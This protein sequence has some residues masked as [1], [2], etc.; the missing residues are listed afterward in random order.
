MGVG[1]GG[2]ISQCDGGWGWGRGISQCDG[3]GV[4]WGYQPV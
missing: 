1:W 2:G 3:G 4:G